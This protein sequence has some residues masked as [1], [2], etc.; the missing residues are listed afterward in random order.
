LRKDL[1]VVFDIALDDARAV[2]QH[3]QF[4]VLTQHVLHMLVLPHIQHQGRL[5][6]ENKRLAG[7]W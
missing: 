1:G 4:A 7:P 3:I 6:S 5:G 2:D